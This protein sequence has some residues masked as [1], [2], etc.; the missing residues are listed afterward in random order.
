MSQIR[1]QSIIASVMVYIGFAL[2]FINTYLFTKEGGFTKEEYGL[3]GI[4]VAIASLMYAAANLGMPAYIGKFYPYYKS[5]V[6]PK[7]NDL[8]T[9]GLVFSTIGFFIVVIAGVC[10]KDLIILKFGKNSPLLV[11]YYYWIFPLGLGLTLYS[12]LEAYAWQLHRAIITNF[13]REIQFRLFATVLIILTLAG[14]IASFDLFIK[15]YSFTYM[16]IALFLLIYLLSKKEIHFTFKTSIVTKKFRSKI[17]TLVSFVFGGALVYGISLIFDSLVIASVLPGG[18]ESVAIFSLGQYMAS[19]I[20]AP[21][22][23]ILAS[24]VGPLSQAWKDKNM[25]K[26]DRI[27]KQSSINLLIFASGMFA[28]IWLNFT[29]GILTFNL[30]KGYLD[31]K[32]VFFFV[33]LYRIVD[34][35]TGVNSQIIGT[36]TLWRFEFFT[37]IILILIT[38]PLTYVL[39]KNPKLGILGPPVATLI[40]FIV[41]NGIRY[42][43]L[44]YKFKLQPFTI[45]TLYTVLLA[46]FTYF[47][48]WLLFRQQ[49]GFWWMVIR[50]TVFLSIYIFGMLKL[51][52]SSD[53]LPVWNTLLKKI[54]IKK[55]AVAS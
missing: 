33:G 23:G 48:C 34:M 7:E 11:H 12:I 36:S 3:V 15:I 41:Y 24:S 55:E 10:F 26:I 39:T 17:L 25:A 52:L 44:L 30:Q 32:W 4:F 38:L 20:Q 42:W 40:S 8:L 46:L 27:Y 35:G 9:W 14:F 49:Q 31:A 19:L 53:V 54:G 6:Q 18:L 16:G 1:R 51:E 50:S 47:V 21:Q 43:F 22:R 2:G 29:D 28:L 45:K 37:G 5:N 13:L